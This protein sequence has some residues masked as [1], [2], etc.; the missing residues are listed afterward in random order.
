MRTQYARGAVHCEGGWGVA[1]DDTKTVYERF[2]TY[3]ITDTR[4]SAYHSSNHSYMV[5]AFKWLG[6][7]IAINYIPSPL[8]SNECQTLP[9]LRV[10]E[11]YSYPNSD[12]PVH[13]LT[14]R[15][16]T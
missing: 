9:Q 8:G 13:F 6:I 5:S 14:K 2:A 11:T 10:I 3:R 7:R 15:R 16:A 4:R 12:E 1:G